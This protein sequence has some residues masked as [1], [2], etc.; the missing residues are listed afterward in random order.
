MKLYIFFTTK[1]KLKSQNKC[2]CR[3]DLF[4]ERIQQKD[5]AIPYNALTYICLTV[6][7]TRNKLMQVSMTFDWPHFNKVALF[8]VNFSLIGKLRSAKTASYGSI[9]FKNPLWFVFKLSDTR[10]P[11]HSDRKFIMPDGLKLTRNFP[12]WWCL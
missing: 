4:Y 7:Q 5:K 2:T 3:E 10:P 12:V 6:T 9:K 8:K 11:Q 1:S